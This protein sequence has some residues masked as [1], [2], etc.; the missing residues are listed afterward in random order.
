MKFS[1]T[2]IGLVDDEQVFHWIA[3]KFIE[4]IGN[5]LRHT[6]FYNGAE[7]L[8]YLKDPNNEIPSILFLDINMP[9]VNG[10]RFLDAFA[11]IK[12]TLDKDTNI[13][14]VS[15]SVDPEDHKKAKQYEYVNGFISKP[16]TQEIIENLLQ[17]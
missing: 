6:S 16:L 13:Y 7:A 14:I 10:W 3:E 15:S 17:G 8:E 12:D 5:G 4:K 9:I 11:T 2:L 1:N